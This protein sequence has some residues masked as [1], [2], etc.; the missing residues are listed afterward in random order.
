MSF[1]FNLSPLFVIIHFAVQT[2]NFLNLISFP[3][4][5]QIVVVV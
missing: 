1:E 2:F 5:S 3:I 4:A